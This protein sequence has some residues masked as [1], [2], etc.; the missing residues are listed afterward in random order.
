MDWTH[1]AQDR[2]R[3]LALVNK[4]RTFGFHKIRGILDKL[5]NYYLFKK[6]CDPLSGLVYRNVAKIHVKIIVAFP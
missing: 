5:K 3:M 6:E 4:V 1:L 2:D